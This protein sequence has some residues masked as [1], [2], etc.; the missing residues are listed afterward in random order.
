MQTMSLD[1]AM[2]VLKGVSLMVGLG[3]T[4][5]AILRYLRKEN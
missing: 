2:F 3:F 5:V 1:D 4:F